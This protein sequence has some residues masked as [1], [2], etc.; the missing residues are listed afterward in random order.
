MGYRSDETDALE[1]W[2]TE[3]EALNDQGSDQEVAE[4]SLEEDIEDMLRLYALAKAA[5][6]GTKIQCPTCKALHKKTSY[7]KVFCRNKGRGNC[8]DRYW[9]LTSD[10]RRRRAIEFQ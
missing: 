3:A 6:V 8:K 5:S 7:Q 10:E 1:E 4:L 2:G 9:N